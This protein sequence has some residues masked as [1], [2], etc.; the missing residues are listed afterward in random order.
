MKGESKAGGSKNKSKATINPD[1]CSFFNGF[2]LKVSSLTVPIAGKTP[3]TP[4]V[5]K[6]TPRPPSPSNIPPKATW[7]KSSSL[8]SVPRDM[9]PPRPVSPAS[10]MAVTE[11]DSMSSVSQLTPVPYE[12]FDDFSDSECFGPLGLPPLVPKGKPTNPVGSSSIPAL[13]RQFA[14]SSISSDA[15]SI[16]ATASQSGY[17]EDYDDDSDEDPFEFPTSDIISVRDGI[18]YDPG[19]AP[20]MGKGPGKG[21]RGQGNV[22]TESTFTSSSKN[23]KD[24]SSKVVQQYSTRTFRKIIE[25]EPCPVHGVI[26][27]KGICSVMKKRRWEK[28]REEK[29][30][31]REGRKK[32]GKELLERDEKGNV[33]DD[34]ETQQEDDSP[35]DGEGEVEDP[36]ESAV[37]SDPSVA[38]TQSSATESKKPESRGKGRKG[39]WGPKKGK[40]IINHIY[41]VI[42]RRTERK[43]KQKP[44]LFDR[45]SEAPASSKA[46]SSTNNSSLYGTYAPSSHRSTSVSEF[47][48]VPS[49]VGSVTTSSR[50]TVKSTSIPPSSVWRAPPTSPSSFRRANLSQGT[51][52]N[53][54]VMMGK[55]GSALSDTRS[56]TGVSVGANAE[57]GKRKESWRTPFEPVV[58][59]IKVRPG[60]Q[61][62]KVKPKTWDEMVE[63]GDTE[64]GSIMSFSGH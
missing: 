9:P 21:R 47:A 59:E 25:E 28:E 38:G 57:N 58:P 62:K 44:F 41:M 2:K 29:K 11:L 40:V 20:R 8:A 15:N 26:C 49:I 18:T 13:Q 50:L 14:S 64:L 34:S 48:S 3:I 60:E 32:S 45:T 46:S 10:A 17:L 16:A 31:E 36:V 7:A 33:V 52:S 53:P 22:V 61:V 56:S 1:A 6:S 37:K 42:K 4:A 5:T 27:S 30:K 63:E 43:A 24:S 39:D 51:G 35:A 55:G 19:S 23:Q 12:S 54:P